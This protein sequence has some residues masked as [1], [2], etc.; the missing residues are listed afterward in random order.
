MLTY[1]LGR[2]DGGYFLL[3]RTVGFQNVTYSLVLAFDEAG[4][5]RRHSLVSV[6]S[7]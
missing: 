3:A 2:D 4:L 6:K 7:P 1:R 5:L